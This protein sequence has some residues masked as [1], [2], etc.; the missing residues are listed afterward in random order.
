M[1]VTLIPVTDTYPLRLKVL[2]PGGTIADTHFDTDL[3]DGTFHLGVYMDGRIVAVGSFHPK[4]HSAL[5]GSGQYQL[6]GMATDP[7]HAGQGHGSALLHAGL[8]ELERR[9]AGLLWCNARIKAVPF[10]LRNGFVIE[11][12]LF[13]I[14]G[15]GPH[16][17]MHR[18]VK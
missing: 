2:R 16:H 10:Y 4:A 7:D 5:T 17:L 15:I 14:P 8:E 18:P 11:G 6:R 9:G 13:D 12:P 1:S 3:I